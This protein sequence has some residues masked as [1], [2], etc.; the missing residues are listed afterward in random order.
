MFELIARIGSGSYADVF[1]ARIRATGE[2]AAV[3]VI[4]LDAN[5]QLDEINKEIDILK[6]CS[7]P[8][9]VKY[10]GYYERAGKQPGQKQIWVRRSPPQR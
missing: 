8:N 2:I 1:R 7:H 10:L 9:I 6:K 3:K 4:I 5:E